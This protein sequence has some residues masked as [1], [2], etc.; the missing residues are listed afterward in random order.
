MQTRTQYPHE[1]AILKA[2]LGMSWRCL[3]AGRVQGQQQ[4]LQHCP[5]IMNAVITASLS[6]SQRQLMARVRCES[7][8]W[9]QA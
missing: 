7:G 3:A 6:T 9:M 1:S 8:G 4:L 2:V 5:W